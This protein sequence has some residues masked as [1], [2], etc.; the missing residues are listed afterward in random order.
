MDDEMMKVVSISTVESIAR[1][2]ARERK[3]NP[4]CRDFVIMNW[5]GYKKGYEDKGGS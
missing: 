1:E 2:K 3:E 5:A 4:R